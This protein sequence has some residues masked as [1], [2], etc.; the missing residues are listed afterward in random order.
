MATWKWFPV[1][2]IW[3]FLD[4]QRGNLSNSPQQ[5]ADTR[6]SSSSEE[7]R[8]GH[9]VDRELIAATH[10]S[11]AL[12]VSG[13]QS[14]PEK[15]RREQSSGQLQCNQADH[16]GL[17]YRKCSIHHNIDLRF[18]MFYIRP[19]GI[20][21]G[22]LSTQKF[23]GRLRIHLNDKDMACIIL[24]HRAFK[25]Y[26]MEPMSTKLGMDDDL[27][28]RCR[29]DGPEMRG[30][31]DNKEIPFTQGLLAAGIVYGGLHSLAWNGP[32]ATNAERML[33]QISSISIAMPGI[34]YIV[35]HLVISLC[36]L[37]EPK[38]GSVKENIR[39]IYESLSLTLSR[40]VSDIAFSVILVPSTVVIIIVFWLLY[41]LSRV[42]IVAECFISV[43]HLP[44]GAFD[45]PQW[46][47][48]V[49]HIN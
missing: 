17:R 2:C 31:F 48:Y 4:W 41:F 14:V 39:P 22:P 12:E 10:D 30:A 35:L 18:Q 26:G 1:S 6:D 24:A 34:L 28:E 43:A 29:P 45:V 16:I 21:V 36:R 19:R 25:D 49:P 20:S 8:S 47:N 40:D 44:D 33:W 27:L 9:L 46:A 15:E 7:S 5:T 32:F 37:A 23:D 11:V 38:L 42:Y 13:T 3:L